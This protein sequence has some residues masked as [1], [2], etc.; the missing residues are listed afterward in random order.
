MKKEIM[1]HMPVLSLAF[2]WGAPRVPGPLA[3]K[4]VKYVMKKTSPYFIGE[5]RIEKSQQIKITG[6]GGV[7]CFSA[8]L[9]K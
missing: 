9:Y 5:N 8:N 7:S 1:H 2:H 3:S 6:G 4:F